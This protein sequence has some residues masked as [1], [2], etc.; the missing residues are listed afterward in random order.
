[1]LIHAQKSS[2]F[3]NVGAWLRQLRARLR[4]YGGEDGATVVNERYGRQ[5]G[6]AR[7]SFSFLTLENKTIKFKSINVGARVIRD[8]PVM[9]KKKKKRLSKNA[10]N[11]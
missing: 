5:Y 1:M 3:F 7:P 2:R 11:R 10:F 6:L 8:G 4:V 9:K